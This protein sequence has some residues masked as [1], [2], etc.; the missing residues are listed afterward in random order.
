MSKRLGTELPATVRR[1]F[2]IGGLKGHCTGQ[3]GCRDIKSTHAATTEFAHAAT[4]ASA[5]ATHSHAARLHLRGGG[6]ARK[7]ER[8]AESK[9]PAQSR[10][11]DRPHG[12]TVRRLYPRA[13]LWLSS[14]PPR[15]SSGSTARTNPA[16]VAAAICSIFPTL[17][18]RMPASCFPTGAVYRTCHCPK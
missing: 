11:S 9:G 12:R 8:R 17:A 1:R 2:G 4:H 14:I 7:S 3:C 10:G 6:L 5:H 16:F 15:A 13:P 18:E